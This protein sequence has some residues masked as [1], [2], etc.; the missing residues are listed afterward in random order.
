VAEPLI[1]NGVY[2][3]NHRDSDIQERKI[4]EKGKLETTNFSV[5]S[6]A[7][8]TRWRKQKKRERKI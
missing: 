5:S 7:K 1:N 6:K 8:E 3:K 2:P 4:V